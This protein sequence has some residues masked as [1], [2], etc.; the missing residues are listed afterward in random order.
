MCTVILRVPTDPGEPV[1]LLAV[2]DED[3]ERPWQ[4]LGAWWPADRPGVVGVR[5]ARAG[6]AWLAASRKRL[7][8]LLNRSSPP[9]PQGVVRVSRGTIVLDAVTG[10]HARPTPALGG[11]NLLDAAPGGARVTSWDG[12]DVAE[13]PVPPGTH[14]IA[15]HD[16]DDPRSARIGTWLPA[17]AAAET[18]PSPGGSGPEWAREWLGI[19]ADSA[20]L[21]PGDDRAIIR[22]N[23]AHGFPTL[24]LLLCVASLGPSGVEVHYGELDRPGEW[25]DPVLRPPSPPAT[26]G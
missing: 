11:F 19:L 25:N 6:G 18:R 22:D 15:H 10:G 4:P 8:V 21:H 1:R 2:R 5:D 20:R 12:V 24:S 7:A 16:L 13:R 23:R 17:F 9:A 3:P 26:R 14:M